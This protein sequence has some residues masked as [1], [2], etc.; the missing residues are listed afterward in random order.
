M[1]DLWLAGG[2]WPRP[3]RHCPVRVGADDN[4]HLPNHLATPRWPSRCSPRTTTS[5]SCR[6]PRTGRHQGHASSHAQARHAHPKA[7][8]LWTRLGDDCIPFLC[9]SSD[10]GPSRRPSGYFAMALPISICRQTHPNS[11]LFDWAGGSGRFACGDGRCLCSLS[12][13]PS[14][15]I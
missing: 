13:G 10:C 1:A 14:G 3:S 7:S 8:L 6:G 12:Q 15:C 2:L 9:C 4:G 5:F 11:S